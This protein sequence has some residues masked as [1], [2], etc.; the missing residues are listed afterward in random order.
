M[1]VLDPADFF[2]VGLVVED[3][4]SAMEELTRVLGLGWRGRIEGV[5]I[6]RRGTQERRVP[7][8][9]VYS[10]EGPPYVELI[11][12]LPGTVWTSP[13]LHHF[14]YWAQDVSATAA[15]LEGAGVPE[16]AGFVRDGQLLGTYHRSASGPYIELIAASS[17]ARIL[18]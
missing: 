3:V 12:A 8:D 5:S 10:I 14:G 16:V 13:G 18:K 4:V 2:H 11:R 6:M 1:A 7:V 15:R 17:R 9:A